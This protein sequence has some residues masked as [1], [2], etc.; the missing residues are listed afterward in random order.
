MTK[1]GAKKDAAA[2]G[3][4][5][6]KLSNHTQRKY[7][8]RKKGAL[9]IC[10]PDDGPIAHID[11]TPLPVGTCRWKD[12]PSAR[13]SVC[14]WPVVRCDQQPTRTVWPCRRL[15]PRGPGTG[16]TC[17][18]LYGCGMREHL[19]TAGYHM[20]TV[21]PEEDQD[22]QA[23]ACTRTRGIRAQR[24]VI[25]LLWLAFSRGSGEGSGEGCD[26]VYSSKISAMLLTS[27]RMFLH[28]YH[29]PTV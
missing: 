9:C 21:L 27:T 10:V 17:R 1:R 5:E 3:E 11:C 26:G 15:H 13:D 16:G 18:E 4:E 6:K 24:D 19:L 7:E 14:R 23:E 12:R 20:Y 22:R 29:C 25:D 28:H 2:E 8:E